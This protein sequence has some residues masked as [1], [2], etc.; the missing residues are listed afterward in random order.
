MKIHLPPNAFSSL[1]QMMLGAAAGRASAHVVFLSVDYVDARGQ[2]AE[3]IVEA[4]GQGGQAA[5]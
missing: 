2:R 3:G 1:R 5:R 4:C